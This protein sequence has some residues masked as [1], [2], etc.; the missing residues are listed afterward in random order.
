MTLKPQVII[1]RIS[2]RKFVNFKYARQMAMYGWM[3]S[4][5]NKT[6]FNISN[7]TFKSNMLLVSSIPPCNCGVFSLN[8]SHI[9]L[10]M[11]MFTDLLK[12]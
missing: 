10:G 11:K 12:E 8:G 2:R 3:L 5:A 7:P 9:N 1:L 6:T 4:L